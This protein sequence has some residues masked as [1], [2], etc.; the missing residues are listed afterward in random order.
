MLKNLPSSLKNYTFIDLFA[1]IGGFHLGLGSLGAKCVLACEIDENARTTY[2]NNFPNT[3]MVNDIKKLD[4]HFIPNYDILCAGFPCQP[5]SISGRRKG[6]EDDRGNLFFEIIRI[7]KTTKPKV[8]FLENVKNLLKH[9]K[10]R[11]FKVIKEELEKVGYTLFYKVLDSAYFLAATSRQ[12]LYIVAFRKD[13]DVKNFDFP[14]YDYKN[15]VVIKDILIE[16]KE[17]K[18]LFIDKNKHN[19]TL[20]QEKKDDKNNPFKPLRVGYTNTARQG[21]RIYSI[22]HVGVTLLS[23]G[24]G[25]FAKT[26]GYLINNEIRRLSVRECA[27]MMGFGDEFKI[28]TNK[29]IGYKQFGNAVVVN[30]ISKIGLEIAKVLKK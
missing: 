14:A 19:L 29:G 13:L 28:P 17:T 5:F 23:Q 8:V 4:A 7:L 16:D 12:R 6:F 11:T 27:R 21:E 9:D 15:P 25:L 3:L 2:L 24:G 20:N 18:K 10:Q 22:N 30:V 1:G 26:G